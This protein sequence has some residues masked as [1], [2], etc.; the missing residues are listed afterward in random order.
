MKK[1]ITVLLAIL[2]VLLGTAF[3]WLK[4]QDDVNGPVISFPEEPVLYE[5][6][7]DT[8]FLLEGVTAIDEEDG[9]V[10]DTLVVDS[11]IPMQNETTA[12]ILYYARDKS[13][14][15]SRA[16][17]VV[18]YMPEGGVLWLLETEETEPET[19]AVTE[20]ETEYLPP[21]CP[22]ITLIT[23]QDT[24]SYVDTSI[25]LAYVKNITDDV[26]GPDWLYT[27]IHIDG[28]HDI[29]GPGVYELY[30]SVVDRD[31]NFSNRAKL[32]LTVQ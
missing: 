17:R 26:D 6:G 19:E 1:I 21:E 32:M 3:Y 24:V 5:A 14:N 11:V 22:R 2:C 28:M 7:A 18:D 23:D 29:S 30:Y 16:S 25:L 8:A 15:V 12:T 13:N 10:S 9:D 31:G 20:E 27:Q 4:T